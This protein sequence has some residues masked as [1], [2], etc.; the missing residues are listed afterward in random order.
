MATERRTIII[1]GGGISGLTA[2]L[3]LAKTGH[4]IQVL[5]RTSKP[6]TA[7]AGV[8]ISPNAYRIL[9][10][11]GLERKLKT[12]ATAPGSIELRNA[13]T[14]KQI[15]EVPL[16]YAASNRYGVPYLVGHRA[17]IHAILVNACK[18]HP[19]IDLQMSSEVIDVVAH[20]NGVTALVR[21]LTG[22]N[23]VVGKALVVADGIGSR[24]RRQTLGLQRPAYSGST[25]WRA[26]VPIVGERDGATHEN[27]HLWLGPGSHAVTYPIRSGR[28]LNVVAISNE[29]EPSKLDKP[30]VRILKERYA[31]WHEDFTW[32]F[33]SKA[34]WSVWPLFEVNEI[35]PMVSGPI[36][37]IGDAAHAMLPQAAQGAAMAIEDAAVLALQV[38]EH[39]N[40]EQAF[41]AYQG[42]R[43][44][45]IRRTM[46]LAR[47]N[48]A[49]YHLKQPLSSCRDFALKFMSGQRLLARQDWL[50]N[51][52]I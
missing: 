9:A 18:D 48:A 32:V 45:R 35:K 6:D 2:A 3:A 44:P 10:N 31:D 39:D 34:Q 40:I 33:D 21:Q 51:W 4:R 15:A 5:E 46:R 17:D 43:I 29:E 38:E 25:A 28:H 19:E 7:G 27:T 47:T 26:L 14:G 8:Q 13:Q 16:G 52:H 50:Y 22:V 42:A 24:I 49:I 41:R 12:I 37:L 1:S 30:N 36:A 23:E 11:L 20:R